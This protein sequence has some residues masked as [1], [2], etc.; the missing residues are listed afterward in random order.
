MSTLY[1]NQTG[2]VIRLTGESILITKDTDPDGSGPL[3]MVREKLLEVELHKIDQIY[4]F[5]K[6]TVTTDAIHAL[7]ERKI[8]VYYFSKGGTFL[9]RYVPSGLGTIEL[10]MKQFALALDTERCLQHS[11]RVV[12]AKLQNAK[13]V[14]EQLRSNDTAEGVYTQAIQSIDHYQKRIE[15]TQ[16]IEQVRGFEGVAAATYFRALAR[17]FKG[18]ITFTERSQ[19][20]PTDPANALLSLAYVLLTAK[21]E[22][23]LEARG[24]DAECGFFHEIRPN[25]PS[26]ALDLLEEFRH[27]IVDRFVMRM[28]NLR[29][30]TKN[31]FEEDEDRYGGVRLQEKKRKLFFAEWENFL[32]KP[33]RVAE[34]ESLEVMKLVER[35]VQQLATALLHQQPYSP[36]YFGAS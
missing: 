9:G 26:L 31:D 33:I 12:H 22:G 2:S 36:Y 29:V 15:Q 10:R 35:Q 21:I 14:L 20:P 3:G 19:R 16:T 34:N 23:L 27:P 5:G 25:R 13:T 4:L 11:K 30:F 28:C 17:S 18:D 32:A 1:V 8:G 24:F 7:F 6:I